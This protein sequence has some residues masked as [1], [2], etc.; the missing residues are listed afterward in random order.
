MTVWNL[1][2]DIVELVYVFSAGMPRED[3]GGLV[4]QMRRAAVAIPTHLAEGHSSGS[5]LA[6]LRHIRQARSAMAEVETHILIAERLGWCTEEITSE[7]LGPMERLRELNQGLERYM[8]KRLQEE[9]APS[10]P[11][12][13]PSL[14]SS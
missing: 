10:P 2:L 5:M 7:I 9:Q 12:S 1:A 4:S 14:K 6:Y 3:V 13:S 8:I 11:P